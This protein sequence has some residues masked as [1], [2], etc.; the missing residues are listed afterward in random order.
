MTMLEAG[1][2]C[3]ANLDLGLAETI[4]GL[5]GDGWKVEEDKKK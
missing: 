4:I 5:N 1:R 3:N 2:I